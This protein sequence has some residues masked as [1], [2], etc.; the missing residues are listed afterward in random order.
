LVYL[1]FRRG[2]PVD[3][4]LPLLRSKAV[5]LDP[6]LLQ[7]LNNLIALD[8]EKARKVFAEHPEL[9]RVVYGEIHKEDLAAKVRA[10]DSPE[11]FFAFCELLDG[12]QP[13][14]HTQK[15]QGQLTWL[16]VVP[17]RRPTLA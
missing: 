12:E 8:P 17:E 16:S 11:S 2:N 7:E 6:K 5:S 4:L 1:D 3:T 9:T 15:G 10:E 14:A 13:P